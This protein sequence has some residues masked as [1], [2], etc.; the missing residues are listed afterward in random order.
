MMKIKIMLD[1]ISL[2]TNSRKE[3]IAEEPVTKQR[4]P[5]TKAPNVATQFIMKKRLLIS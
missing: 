5:M 4:N 3:M 1:K 2:R